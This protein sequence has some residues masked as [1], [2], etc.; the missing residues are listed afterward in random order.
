LPR[1]RHYLLFVNNW[2]FYLVSSGL[3]ELAGAFVIDEEI[4]QGINIM[5]IHTVLDRQFLAYRLVG[6]VI[7]AK[8]LY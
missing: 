4:P 8:S 3:R 7:T 5:I 2:I 6:I 1:N